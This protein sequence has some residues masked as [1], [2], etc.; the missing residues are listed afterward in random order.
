VGGRDD[1]GHAARDGGRLPDFDWTIA[2]ARP[3]R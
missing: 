2:A 3:V 1:A